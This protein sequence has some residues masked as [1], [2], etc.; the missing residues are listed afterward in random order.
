MSRSPFDY[1]DYDDGGDV[2]S[3]LPVVRH[4]EPSF[5]ALKFIGSWE[6]R[7]KAKCKGMTEVFFSKDRETKAERNARITLAQS[8]CATCEGRK[9]CFEFAK[10]ND[11]QDGVW[12]GVNFQNH[13]SMKNPRVIPDSID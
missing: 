8:I 5:P 13:R 9:Q 6:W 1:N 10:K 11:E 4:K 3:P 2:M 7:D 12:G